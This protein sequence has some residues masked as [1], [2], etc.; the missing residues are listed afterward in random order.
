MGKTLQG[1][2]SF[3]K[4]TMKNIFYSIHAITLLG[5]GLA[6]VVPA[7]PLASGEELSNGSTDAFSC[8]DAFTLYDEYCYYFSTQDNPALTWIQAQLH[9]RAMDHRATLVRAHTAPIDTYIRDELTNIAG[10]EGKFSDYWMD[11]N[12]VSVPYGVSYASGLYAY[13]NGDAP[14]FTNWWPGEPNNADREHC[15]RYWSM[16]GEFEWH[17]DNY[18]CGTLKRYICQFSAL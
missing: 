13:T 1:S 15:V 7:N 11:L 3:S 10:D 9:C 4:D 16:N 17:W 6:S 8:P 18:N 12:I 2:R 5:V 14:V